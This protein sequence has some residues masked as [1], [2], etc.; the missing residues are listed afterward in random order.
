MPYP[1]EKM[2]RE[3]R[4]APQNEV[5]QLR[6]QE[7]PVEPLVYPLVQFLGHG[8]NAVPGQSLE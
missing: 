3:V 8:G 2:D 4:H 7:S 5:N 1:A 6:R